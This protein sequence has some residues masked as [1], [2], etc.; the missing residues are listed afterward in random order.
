MCELPHPLIKKAAD[1]FGENSADDNCVGPIACSSTLDLL[2]IKAGQWR[3][4]IWL[5]AEQEVA[6]LVAGGLAKGGHD[7]RDDFYER[8]GRDDLNGGLD[9]LLPTEEDRRLLK[10]ETAAR[11][12][13]DWELRVQKQ[14][15]D[16]LL[17]VQCGGSTRFTVEHVK[18]SPGGIADIE[19]EIVQVRDSDCPSDDILVT[20]S[21]AC[22]H[23]GT[24]LTWNLTT[25]ILISL[26]PPWQGW[27]RFKDTY[28]NIGEPGTW[29]ER[30]SA[31]DRLV[32][33]QSLAEPQPGEH[34]HRAHRRHL[35]QSTDRAG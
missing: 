3:G 17:I 11:M 12:V 9:R 14:A 34:A 6:W 4:G 22:Q 28:S 15:R 1:S 13:T 31:L 7:D 35:A 19:I 29:T 10:R 23:L 25:R 8:L 16:A 32:D 21:P 30:V 33:K 20:I 24:S 26:S 2:E 18:A 27:D 5:D